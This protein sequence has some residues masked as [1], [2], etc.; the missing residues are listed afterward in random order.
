MNDIKPPRDFGLLYHCEKHN[1]YYD[2]CR[3]C[4]KNKQFYWLT[5]KKNMVFCELCQSK[6]FD[7]DME[8]HKRS[9]IHYLALQINEI[10]KH[11]KL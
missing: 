3:Q 10:K 1:R 8:K 6:Y 7:F 11:L 4:K 5:Q 2:D 9:S